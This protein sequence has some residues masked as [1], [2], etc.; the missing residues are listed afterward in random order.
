MSDSTN[1]KSPGRTTSE[2]D[3]EEALMRRVMGHAGRGRII[4]TQ[5][6]SNVHRRGVAWVQV[7]CRMQSRV[8]PWCLYRLIQSCSAAISSYPILL[9]LPDAGWGA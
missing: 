6:A 7:L 2:A 9:S 5:F 3:V 8:C 4:T 1:V